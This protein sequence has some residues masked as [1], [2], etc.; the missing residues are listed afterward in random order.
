M[1]PILA[2]TDIAMLSALRANLGR[3]Y[4]RSPRYRDL[5]IGTCP[6]IPQHEDENMYHC[7]YLC[8]V[9][10]GFEYCTGLLELELPGIILA[11]SSNSCV[12]IRM[13]KSREHFLLQKNR[14]KRTDSVNRKDRELIENI[15]ASQSQVLFL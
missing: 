3:I 9:F 2:H 6:L 7:S 5:I 15:T 10:K 11:V 14:A 1:P 12:I 13:V 8:S 4:Q